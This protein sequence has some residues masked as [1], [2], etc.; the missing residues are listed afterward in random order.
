MCNLLLI[1]LSSEDPNRF[2]VGFGSWGRCGNPEKA[3]SLDGIL[4]SF[5]LFHTELSSRGSLNHLLIQL[6][7]WMG[8]RSKYYFWAWRKCAA[9]YITYSWWNHAECGYT[10]TE[11]GDGCW[12]TVACETIPITSFCISVS[13]SAEA[14]S[15]FCLL[16]I[17]LK[18][19][20]CS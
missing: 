12:G 6:I 1:S 16:R 3:V 8:Q 10:I 4:N 13:L 17:F 20:T 15:H 14:E 18:S 11:Q 19:S 5:T 7:L 2:S 9:R